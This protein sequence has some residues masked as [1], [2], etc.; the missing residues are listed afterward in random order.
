MVLIMCSIVMAYL[1][2]MA[3]NVELI[4]NKAQRDYYVFTLVSLKGVAFF[5][6][7]IE[8]KGWRTKLR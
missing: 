1:L 7:C 3:V 6:S 2:A 5:L 4:K 8:N